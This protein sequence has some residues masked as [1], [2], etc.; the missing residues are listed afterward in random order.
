ML[1]PD[2]PRWAELKNA[3]RNSYDPRPLLRRFESTADDGSRWQD[4]WN[5][6]HHQGDVDTA[7][8]AV[9][10]YLVELAKTR[11]VG[12]NLYLFA[13]TVATEAGTHEN[14]P[15]PPFLA[16]EFQEAMRAL[17]ELAVLD[18]RQGGDRSVT[19]ALLAFLAAHANAL[20]LSRAIMD[21]DLFEGYGEQV[22]E[23]EK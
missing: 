7:S 11:G 5:E 4:V 13:A 17:F 14:P 12:W 18:L 6:L 22:I 2:D 8:Y 10:P 16:G 23:A 3:Y 21:I 19:R 15:I 9:L 1:P 20:A